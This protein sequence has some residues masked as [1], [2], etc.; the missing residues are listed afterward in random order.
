MQT[1][2][3][4]RAV[5]YSRQTLELHMALLVEV[6]GGD[7]ELQLH[8]MKRLAKSVHCDVTGEL[9]GPHGLGM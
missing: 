4:P 6:L 1:P 8:A 9:R 5:I 7:R 2:E 3:N